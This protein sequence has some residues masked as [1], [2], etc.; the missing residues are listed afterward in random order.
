MDSLILWLAVGSIVICLDVVLDVLFCDNKLT[1]DSK[2]W[3]KKHPFYFTIF[4]IG[5]IALFPIIIVLNIVNFV[6][7]EF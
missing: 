4:L 6:K 5:A 2:L 3:I 1:R 7:K